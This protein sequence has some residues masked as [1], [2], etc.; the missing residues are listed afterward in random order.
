[1]ELSDNGA[2]IR[3]K[4]IESKIEKPQPYE[5]T[6]EDP[7]EVDPVEKNTLD[8][9]SLLHGEWT[10]IAIDEDVLENRALVFKINQDKTFVVSDNGEVEREGTW[11]VKNNRFYLKDSKGYSSDYTVTIGDGGELMLQDYYGKMKLQKK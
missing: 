2:I 10:V 8:N 1:M 11:E 9:P 3:M 7:I 5:E 6:W 4:R